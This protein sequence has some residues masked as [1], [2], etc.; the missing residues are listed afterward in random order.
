[1]TQHRVAVSV[2]ADATDAQ[3]IAR[4]AG[5]DKTLATALADKLGANSGFT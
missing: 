5:D 3:L 2:M 1:M 4:I